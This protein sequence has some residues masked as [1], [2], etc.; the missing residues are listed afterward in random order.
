[1]WSIGA[2]GMRVALFHSMSESERSRTPKSRQGSSDVGTSYLEEIPRGGFTTRGDHTGSGMKPNP[3]IRRSRRF[4]SRK[5][6]VN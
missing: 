3:D 5:Q 1:M 6:K 4:H 2:K